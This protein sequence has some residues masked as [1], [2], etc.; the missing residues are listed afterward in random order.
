[1]DATTRRI[2]NVYWS[3]RRELKS[4]LTDRVFY[5]PVSQPKPS[6]LDRWII[7]L[8]GSYDARMFTESKPRLI[9]VAK[10]DDDGSQLMDVVSDTLAAIDRTGDGS[11]FIN[12]YDKTSAT[13]I[14][15]IDV[16]RTMIGP[17]MPYDTGID[18]ISIDVFTRIKTDRNM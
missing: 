10:E 16:L 15:T 6:E 8:N 9:C 5:N 1:M 3:W 4:L 13:V 2:D 14:G 17:T 18:S 11:K 12:F 7:F